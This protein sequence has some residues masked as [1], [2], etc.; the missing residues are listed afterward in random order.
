MNTVIQA[1]TYDAI[2]LIE[3]ESVDLVVTDPPYGQIAQEWDTEADWKALAVAFDRV[4]KR[5]GQIYVF[6]KLPFAATILQEFARYFRFRF[7]YIWAK[8]L[9]MFRNKTS[10]V[11]T[12]EIILCFSR[13]GVPIGELTFEIDRI[14]TQGKP[15]KA[16][17]GDRQF[18]GIKDV[19]RKMDHPA[20]PT[21]LRYPRS[22]IFERNMT[23]L[24]EERLGHPTQKPE[25]IV[26]N[27]VVSSSNPGDIIFDPFMGSWTTA[28][29]AKRL[30]RNFLG[31]EREQ[32]Y[33]D[34]GRRRLAKAWLN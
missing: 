5:T 30:R 7:D 12:H 34:I 19:F 27:L 2:W 20:K 9:G 10:P 31:F 24:P 8:P 32:H 17:A 22:V 11:P 28:V 6:C 18:T 26:H 16:N 15:Y 13:V 25:S 33:C 23:G 14:M 21:D 1:D 3:K 29:V 4:L